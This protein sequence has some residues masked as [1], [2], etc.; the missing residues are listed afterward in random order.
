[1]EGGT[2]V[3]YFSTD[4]LDQSLLSFSSRNLVGALQGRGAGLM[5]CIC[6]QL[7]SS[8]ASL[9]G[10]GA[11]RESPPSAVTAGRNQLLE[12]PLFPPPSPSE[13]LWAGG[14]F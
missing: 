2:C 5:H 3:P 1:M 13:C 4:G 8:V 11:Q 6:G 10:G 9:A 12:N 14:V 7:P